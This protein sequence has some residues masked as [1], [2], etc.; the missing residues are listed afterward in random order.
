MISSFSNGSEETDEKGAFT[1]ERAFER[2]RTWK[3]GD[4]I[5]QSQ[6]GNGDEVLSLYC[7]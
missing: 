3:Q 2:G 5:Q 7:T 6:F 4:L 1:Q